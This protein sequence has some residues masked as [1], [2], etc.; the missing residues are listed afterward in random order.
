MY[1]TVSRAIYWNIK[2][3]IT[4]FK[5]NRNNRHNLV[6]KTKVLGVILTSAYV[7]LIIIGIAMSTIQIIPKLFFISGSVLNIFFYLVCTLE[8]RICF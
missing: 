8:K 3:M 2:E 6:S 7:L 4:L 5:S 1:W